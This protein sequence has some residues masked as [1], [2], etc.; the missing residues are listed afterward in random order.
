MKGDIK[1]WGSFRRG[2]PAP[3]AIAAAVVLALF[4]GTAGAAQ[5][6]YMKPSDFIRG[7]FPRGVPAAQTISLSG[8]AG[9]GVRAILGHSYRFGSRVN[10][11]QSGSRTAWMRSNWPRRWTWKPTCPKRQFRSWNMRSRSTPS[12]GGCATSCREPTSDWA[13][14]RRL[15]PNS[16]R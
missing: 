13:G 8:D 6:V 10:Y 14:N 9:S 1:A 2:L 15:K 3:G 11:W 4:A 5:K 16:R 12:N 7:A